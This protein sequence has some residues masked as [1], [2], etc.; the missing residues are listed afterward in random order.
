MAYCVDNDNFKTLAA[1]LA[2]GHDGE[3]TLKRLKVSTHPHSAFQAVI[4]T[5]DSLKSVSAQHMELH[6][7]MAMQLGN[8]PV[9]RTI[10]VER[11]QCDSCSNVEIPDVPSEAQEIRL[12]LEIDSSVTAGKLYLAS[13]GRSMPPK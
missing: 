7:Q 3:R 9:W 10:D 5:P 2:G 13:V 1:L 11:Q 6:A 4:T 8:R 12:N